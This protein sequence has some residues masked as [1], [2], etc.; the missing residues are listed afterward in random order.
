MERDVMTYRKYP[1]RTAG[2]RI[3]NYVHDL[4]DGTNHVAA[5][6]V[7]GP[8]AE[9]HYDKT[10][11]ANCGPW[12]VGDYDDVIEAA[13]ATGYDYAIQY[14]L[15]PPPDPCPTCGVREDH[16]PGGNLC[17]ELQDGAPKE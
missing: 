8:P 14:E 16:V 12:L 6:E 1:S 5:V 9:M 13:E 7:F 17:R 3:D 15:A 2:F 4:H 10:E 11:D